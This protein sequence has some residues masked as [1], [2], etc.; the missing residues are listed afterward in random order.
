MNAAFSLRV[1]RVV[2]L[3]LLSKI[4]LEFIAGVLLTPNEYRLGVP[5]VLSKIIEKIQKQVNLE[6]IEETS[7]S[8]GEHEKVM[9]W[10][11]LDS[12]PS[13]M[14]AV[15]LKDRMAGDTAEGMVSALYDALPNGPQRQVRMQVPPESQGWLVYVPSEDAAELQKVWLGEMQAARKT[16]EK[17]F[18]DSGKK[19]RAPRLCFHTEVPV[20]QSGAGSAES[21]AGSE[22]THSQAAGS[23]CV[24]SMSV[25]SGS[26]QGSPGET[27]VVT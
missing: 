10:P 4:I 7:H 14:I 6:D 9:A 23:S 15:T 3:M 8:S 27:P 20:F 12:V 16:I 26:E 1:L 25:S 21:L 24:H 19:R 11:G 18:R 13:G 5:Q 22:E 17:Q 2:R